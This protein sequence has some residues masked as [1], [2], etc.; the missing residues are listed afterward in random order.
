MKKTLVEIVQE[1]L[2]DLND[3]VINSI[4]DTDEAMQVAT[5]VQ[6]TYQAMLSTR[7]WPH[8]ARIVTLVP[9]GNNNLPTHMT[10]EE[11]IKELISINYD[12]H[13]INDTMLK[14]SPVRWKEPD[15]FLRYTYGRNSTASNVVTISDPSGTKLLI[16][17]DQGPEFYTSFDDN[18]LIFDSYD[19]AVDTTLQSSKSVARA[20]VMPDFTMEDDFIPDLPE[21]AFSALI[22]EAKSKASFKLHQSADQKSEQ[23]SVRQQKWLSRKA[24]RVHGGIRYPNYGR[25]KG[26]YLDPTF[27]Y[28][29]YDN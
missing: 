26:R 2:S 10:I 4:T 9:S 11:N 3:D 12:K 5:I 18:T 25:K 17:N 6:A 22:E 8:T 29:K 27:R 13:K 28:E 21:E 15:D 14:F 20:Y 19:S 1:V 16:I 24:W 7:N 23:E